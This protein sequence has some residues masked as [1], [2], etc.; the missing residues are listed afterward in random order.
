LTKTR[1]LRH[2]PSWPA[3]GFLF[4]KPETTRMQLGRKI[5]R[6][7]SQTTHGYWMNCLSG[8]TQKLSRKNACH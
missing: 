5:Y 2:A 7:G 8:N 3:W 4:S 1:F 6:L